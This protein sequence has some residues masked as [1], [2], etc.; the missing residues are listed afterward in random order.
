MI[1]NGLLNAFPCA[2]VAYGP[3]PDR[4][5]RQVETFTRFMALAKEWLLIFGI[6]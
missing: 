3:P 2:R 1:R 5:L 4:R 6:K